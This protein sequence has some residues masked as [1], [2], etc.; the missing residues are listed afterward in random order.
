MV[1]LEFRKRKRKQTNL[2]GTYVNHSQKDSNGNIIV[3][4]ISVSGLEFTSYDL[5]DFNIDDELTVTFT[6]DDEHLSEITKE[7]VVKDLRKSSVGCEFIRSGELA[8]DGPLGF[9]IMH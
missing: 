6:L 5:Q 3:K 1:N 4:N 2:R 7:V 9:Y 8:F